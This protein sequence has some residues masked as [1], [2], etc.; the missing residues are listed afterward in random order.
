MLPRPAR[1]ELAKQLLLFQ[2]M[3]MSRGGHQ[4][5]V[6]S[7]RKSEWLR[8]ALAHHY[9]PDPGVENEIVV[10][11]TGIDQYLQE[12]F[13]HLAYYNGDDLVSA[14]DFRLLCCVL[15]IPNPGEVEEKLDGDVVQDICFGLPREL[16]FKEFHKRLCG[17]FSTRARMTIARLPVTEETEH[18]EREIRLRWPRVR[19]RK[20][21]SFDLSKDVHSGK[22]TTC[23]P[24][25]MVKPDNMISFGQLDDETDFSPQGAALQQLETENASL[26]ELVEDLRSAL[27][28][29]DARCLALEVALHRQRG[30]SPRTPAREKRGEARATHE[31]R[32][33]WSA[34][35]IKGLLRE[36][37]LIRASR[38]GQLEEA[39]KFNQRL[40]EE[41]QVVYGEGRRMVE[42]VTRLQME[43]GQIKKKAEE[44][45]AA[46]AIGLDRVREIQGQALMVPSLQARVQELE[47]ELQGLR[48]CCT[49]RR[50]PENIENPPSM[51]VNSSLRQFP[52]VSDESWIRGADEGLQ[53]AVEG[54]AASDEEEEE[55]GSEERQCCLVELNKL[56]N[57]LHSCA[58]GC[59]KT[60]VRQLL[61]SQ[62]CSNDVTSSGN[63]MSV[64][65]RGWSHRR[66]TH[67]D[68]KESE[69][70]KLCSWGKDLQL[71]Q[72]EVEMLRM[73]VQM[74]EAERV[75]LSLLEEELTDALTL[76]LQLRTKNISRRALGKILMDTL[77]VCCKNGHGPSHGL[78]VLDTL[79]LQLLSCELLGEEG[80]A[81]TGTGAHRNSA[82]PLLISC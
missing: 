77:D 62:A 12:I 41:L 26:R 27:Q 50:E 39:M 81:W 72:E 20:C 64:E 11:A 51:M 6:R 19:R 13:H 29:S 5:S 30:A 37:D 55:R 23:R 78:Q 53:R 17:Y 46:L 73:E 56:I 45:R 57:R 40:E 52:M 70:E 21:V 74:V 2:V 34:R 15:G 7:S 24:E 38:D 79:C 54:R 31:P 25:P 33:E 65:I 59:Q 58:K 43:N 36:L 16:H 3:E 68:E 8:S 18:V 22:R 61:V 10:L 67:L 35:G 76:L 69:F 42:A 48:D 71:K 28:G 1:N 49:C 9:D 82:N 14:D 80:G 75:R 60:A 4:T 47:T 63:A 66:Y 44:V 32:A